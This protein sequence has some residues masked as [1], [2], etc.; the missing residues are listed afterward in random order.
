[1]SM[2][3]AKL[4]TIGTDLV[5]LNSGQMTRTAPD[6]APSPSFHTTA[7][8]SMG[9]IHGGYSG[10][11]DF[12]PGALGPETETLSLWRCGRSEWITEKNLKHNNSEIK[13]KHP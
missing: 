13:R 11:S 2:H 6:L 9:A 12:E 5:I 3:M 7:W 4:G 10:V 8:R 1:M